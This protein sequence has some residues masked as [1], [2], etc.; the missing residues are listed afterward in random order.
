[1]GVQDWELSLARD[2]RPNMGIK[3]LSVLMEISSVDQCF[4][5]PGIL[6]L[7]KIINLL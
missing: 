7:T 3:K 1:M 2:Y 4:E 5:A 6:K